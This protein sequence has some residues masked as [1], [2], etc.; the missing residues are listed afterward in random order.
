MEKQIATIR[1]IAEDVFE[2]LGS[3]FP[4]TV[5]DHAMQVGL[6]L[7]NFKY[8]NQKV[9]ELKYKDHYVGV[10]YPDLVVQ[11]HN[12]DLVVEIKAVGNIGPA[13]EQQLTNY[14]RLLSV[15]RGLLINFQHPS[16]TRGATTE[17]EIRELPAHDVREP[18]NDNLSE[19]SEGLRIDEPNRERAQGHRRRVS[20]TALTPKAKT[21]RVV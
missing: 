20:S 17:V 4:E 19:A 15:D 3:G 14:M 7:A 16:K 6:R 21:K 8:Q 11:L 13:E 18:S 10:G 12:G 1:N 9:V 2:T 5:Y